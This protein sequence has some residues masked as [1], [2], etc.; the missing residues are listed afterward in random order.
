ML[1]FIENPKL[2]IDEFNQMAAIAQKKAFITIGIEIQKEEIETIQNY[3]KE[4]S[5]L[6]SEFVKRNLENE[7]NL[8]YCIENSLLAI[9]YELQMLVHLKE[10][11]MAEAWD[12]LVRAQVIYGTVISNSPFQSEENENYLNRL[13]R[14]EK[15]LFPNLYFQSV[16]GIIKES[17]CSICNQKSGKCDHIKGKLYKGELCTRVITDI[18]LEEVSLVENPANKHCRVIS[19]EQNGK[20]ID[21]LTLREINK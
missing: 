21:I 5:E 16:G 4:L 2:L 15:L 14:Y 17:H 18:E 1:V 7:A 8:V 9:D 3:L 11:K 19:I 6:K 12:N 20:A 10:D 13:E